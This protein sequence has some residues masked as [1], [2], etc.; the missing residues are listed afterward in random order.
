MGGRLVALLGGSQ[1]TSLASYVAVID[2]PRGELIKCK[3]V[4]L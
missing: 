2:C 3:P 4:S 1:L